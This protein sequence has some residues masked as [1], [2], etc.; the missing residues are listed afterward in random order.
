MITIMNVVWPIEMLYVLF[1]EGVWEIFGLLY[2]VKVSWN[3]PFLAFG[4]SYII[5]KV[6]YF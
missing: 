3:L 5:A 4:P 6:S 1:L 2:L